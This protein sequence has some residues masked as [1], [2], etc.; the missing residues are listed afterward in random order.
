MYN[1]VFLKMVSDKVYTKDNSFDYKTLID[2]SLLGVIREVLKVTEQRQ[3]V[4]K[5]HFFYI[6]FLTR[7][8]GVEIS[9]VLRKKYPES[10]TIIIQNQFKNLQ[11]S[12]DN[13]SVVLSFSGVEM[14][15]KVPFKSIIGFS[16]PSVGFELEFGDDMS[17]LDDFECFDDCDE[18]DSE[19]DGKNIIPIKFK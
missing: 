11:V 13:F 7:Y 18:E 17:I 15:V 19:L 12:R 3:S 6:T 14:S 10:I 4:P 8:N 2:R 1:I 16:D 9:E 5:P